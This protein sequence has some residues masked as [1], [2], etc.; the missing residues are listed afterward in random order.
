LARV[1]KIPHAGI[2]EQKPSF[3]P[4]AISTKPEAA[5]SGGGT[6]LA[7]CCFQNEPVLELANLSA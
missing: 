5:A 6:S 2:D 7:K 3:F 1:R 4:W